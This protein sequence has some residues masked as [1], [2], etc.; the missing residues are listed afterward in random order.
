MAILSQIADQ[1][2]AGTGQKPLFVFDNNKIQKCA[3]NSNMKIDW[4]QRVR[5]PAY[6]PDFNKPIEHTFHRMKDLLVDNY[7]DKDEE[8]DGKRLQEI[9]YD[10]F[11]NQLTAG[12]YAD[13]IKKDV[14]SLKKTWLSVSLDKGVKKKAFDGLEVVGTGGD[15]PV[16][17]LR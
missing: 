7:L 4:S 17:H 3:H 6:S 15:Y 1:H 16:S 9:V 10:I 2:W 14:Y 5:I 13:S 8:I 12:E 11:K